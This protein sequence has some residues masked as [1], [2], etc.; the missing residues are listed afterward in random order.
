MRQKTLQWTL[1]KF[2]HSWDYWFTSPHLSAGGMSAC[3]SSVHLAQNSPLMEVSA[4]VDVSTQ[5]PLCFS[6]CGCS[7]T[8]WGCFWG[9]MLRCLTL[10]LSTT[11]SIVSA[12]ILKALH[13][14]SKFDLL[15]LLLLLLYSF[16][17]TAAATTVIMSLISPNLE[18]LAS[19][20]LLP[21]KLDSLRV[22]IF[23]WEFSL[24]LNLPI[25][26]I[27]TLFLCH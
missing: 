16:F 5:Y 3:A 22:S 27:K 4:W 6:N 26:M 2:L 8:C 7:T 20:G 18:V 12:L 24:L 17:S 15:I 11:K 14:W 19:I 23:V 9:Y 25:S 21:L 13:A 10:S 1:P